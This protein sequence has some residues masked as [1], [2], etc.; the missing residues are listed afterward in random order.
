MRALQVE[1]LTTRYLVDKGPKGSKSK[2]VEAARGR[3]CY[4]LV[5]Q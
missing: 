4:I 2:V 1:G 5:E 3:V